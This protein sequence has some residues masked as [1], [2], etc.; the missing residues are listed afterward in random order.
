MA[1]SMTV[2]QL[3]SELRRRRV[4]LDL[5]LRD[6]EEKTGISPATLSRIERGSKPEFAVIEKLA[7]WL[8]VNVVAAGAETSSIRTDEDLK[9][10]IHVHLR[11]KKNLPEEVAHSIVEAFEI[12]M[13]F[14]LQKA[15]RRDS[16]K[17]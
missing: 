5:T 16:P 11:A 2:E 14:E 12:L 1:V 7:E 4:E 8:G 9:K 17:K 15:K 10:A 13:Q 6:V 3:A